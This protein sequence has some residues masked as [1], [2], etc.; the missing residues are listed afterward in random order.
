MQ[1]SSKLGLICEANKNVY[2][3]YSVI[4]CEVL[5]TNHEPLP[6]QSITIVA[7]LQFIYAILQQVLLL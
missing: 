2:A 1:L 6:K 7:V 5:N 3:N 4:F